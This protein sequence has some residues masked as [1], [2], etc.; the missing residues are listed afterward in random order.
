MLSIFIW[1]PSV[2]SP[3]RVLSSLLLVYVFSNHL[4]FHTYN[5]PINTFISFNSSTNQYRSASTQ[6]Y[7][8]ARMPMEPG[9]LRAKSSNSKPRASI[10]AVGM[11]ADAHRMLTIRSAAGYNNQL[12]DD[13]PDMLTKASTTISQIWSHEEALKG[14]PIDMRLFLANE[15]WIIH[16][17][18]NDVNT[19]TSMKSPGVVEALNEMEEFTISDRDGILMFKQ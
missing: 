1:Q 14:R 18:N 13:N 10:A 11:L 5:Q 3:V 4:I 8:F 6:E 2:H 17:D 9:S 12:P 7:M 16:D 19:T 15:D